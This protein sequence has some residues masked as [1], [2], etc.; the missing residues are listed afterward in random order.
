MIELNEITTQLC[1]IFLRR[2]DLSVAY[3]QS[4]TNNFPSGLTTTQ[5]M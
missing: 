5:L 1:S 4:Q 3:T 2:I